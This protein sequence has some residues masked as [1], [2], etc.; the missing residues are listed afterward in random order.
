LRF[1]SRKY[2]DSGADRGNRPATDLAALDIA[3]SV[4]TQSDAEKN[5]RKLTYVLPPK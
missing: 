3:T 4:A 2:F 1:C 5:G